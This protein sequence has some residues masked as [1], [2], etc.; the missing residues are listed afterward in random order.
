MARASCERAFLTRSFFKLPGNASTMD[1]DD[2][3]CGWSRG[4]G[5]AR[6]FRRVL[7]RAAGGACGVLLAVGERLVGARRSRS[8]ARGARAESLDGGG[9][10]Q[11]SLACASAS[12]ASCSL[13]VS[14]TTMRSP[15]RLE[16]GRTR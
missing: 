15:V 16:V 2:L 3:L 5:R 11:P 8:R 14:G 7:E 4:V 13:G 1:M 9:H 12:I 10:A 6:R